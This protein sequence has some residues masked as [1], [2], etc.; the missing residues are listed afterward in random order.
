MAGIRTPEPIQNLQEKMPEVYTA[1]Q[2]Y[3]YILEDH[4]QRYAGYRIYNRKGQALY[5]A[6]P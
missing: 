1:F 6:N 2:E 3:A 4:Y 5:P